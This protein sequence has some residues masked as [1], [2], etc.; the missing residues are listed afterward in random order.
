MIFIP[1]LWSLSV[2]ASE[3]G[4]LPGKFAV[5]ITDLAAGLSHTFL[6]LKRCMAT[7]L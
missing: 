6:G 4:E 5:G 1:G 2:R 3:L 7:F